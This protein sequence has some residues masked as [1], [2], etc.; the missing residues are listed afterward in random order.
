VACTAELC[1][2]AQK[3][4]GRLKSGTQKSIHPTTWG[5]PSACYGV[6]TQ[7][8]DQ[9]SAYFRTVLSSTKNEDLDATIKTADTP[10]VAAAVVAADVDPALSPPATVP[11]KPPPAVTALPAK[12]LT[13]QTQRGGKIEPVTADPSGTKGVEV[14]VSPGSV[15][16]TRPHSA[17][18]LACSLLPS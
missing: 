2:G 3:Y 17:I 9:A 5:F 16:S 15:C 14:Q 7:Q 10:P 4:G 8:T 12:Y 13:P 18:A 6:H 11:T 1:G